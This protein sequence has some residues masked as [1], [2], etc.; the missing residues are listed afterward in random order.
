MNDAQAL[1]PAQEPSLAETRPARPA[2]YWF[3]LLL[4][5]GSLSLLVPLGLF[6][7]AGIAL[8]EPGG[9]GGG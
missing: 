9:C 2:S 6:L 1:P 5:L 4:V 3:K 8:G 7:F